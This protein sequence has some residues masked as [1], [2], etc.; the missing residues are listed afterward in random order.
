MKA[1]QQTLAKVR[2][3]TIESFGM[4]PDIELDYDTPLAPKYISDGHDLVY[5]LDDL[6]K[7]FQL[8]DL[9]DCFEFTEDDIGDINIR[10][11]ADVIEAKFKN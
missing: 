2:Q 7:H 10:T 6:E 1:T 8:E 4:P 9:V 5:L 11:I 3:L